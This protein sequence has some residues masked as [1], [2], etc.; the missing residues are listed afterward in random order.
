MELEVVLREGQADA[1]GVAIAEAL[2]RDLG[3]AAAPRVAGAYLDLLRAAP[4]PPLTR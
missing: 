2:M 3:L 4:S 1:E